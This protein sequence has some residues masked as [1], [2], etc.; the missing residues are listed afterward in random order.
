MKIYTKE[1]CIFCVKA[2][3]KLDACDISYTELRVGKDVSREHLLQLAP[4]AK[5]VPQIF[6]DDGRLI[7]G[8]KELLLYI[9]SS[10]ETYKEKV[11]M[12]IVAQGELTIKSVDSIPLNAEIEEVTEKHEKGTIL[13]HSESGNHHIL[14]GDS[15]VYLRTNDVPAGN[16]IMYANIKEDTRVFQDAARPHKA[17]MLPKGIY[18]IRSAREYDPFTKQARIVAD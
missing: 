13:A 16:R 11:Q 17:Q 18:E 12:I 1:D 3:E 8:Y 6:H 5:T 4:G 9:E 10:I 7:G 2:K 15:K 14:A